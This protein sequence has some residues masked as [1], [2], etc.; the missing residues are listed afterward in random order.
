MY[1]VNFILNMNAQSTVYPS[2]QHAYDC[3]TALYRYCEAVKAY[4]N[5][6]S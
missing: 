5:S 3:I 2:M 1:Y 4:R 6:Q